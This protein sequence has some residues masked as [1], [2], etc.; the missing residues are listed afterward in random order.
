[1]LVQTPQ[2]P[3]APPPQTSL[4]LP[5]SGKDKRE[6]TPGLPGRSGR[7]RRR[8]S[9]RRSDRGSSFE[10]SAS[11]PESPAAKGGRKR[12]RSNRI[13][14]RHPTADPEST[15]SGLTES[16]LFGPSG[17]L[18]FPQNQL[19]P[20]DNLPPAT[21]RRVNRVKQSLTTHLGGQAEFQGA[22]SRASESSCKKNFKS[23]TCLFN[24]S[25]L[26]ETANPSQ[27]EEE[28]PNLSH[29]FEAESQEE[30]GEHGYEND[31]TATEPFNLSHI[32]EV[33]SQ[34]HGHDGDTPAEHDD[35]PAPP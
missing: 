6:P 5:P 21:L 16:S 7:S 25:E 20:E 8:S 32:F 24:E 3:Q 15:S 35:A 18:G 34:E 1:M 14:I 9:G 13:L 17:Q 23:K 4:S 2:A 22:S 31:D 26:P 27:S 28:V 29:L 30:P 11:E 12:H 10:R 19:F 33:D